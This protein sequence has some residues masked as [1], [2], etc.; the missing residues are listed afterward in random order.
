MVARMN[1]DHRRVGPMPPS[2]NNAMIDGAGSSGKV[3]APPPSRHS[4]TTPSKPK[5]PSSSS[6]SASMTMPSHSLSMAPFP[7]N[8]KRMSMPA[9]SAS[10]SSSAK[11]GGLMRKSSN[12]TSAGKAAESSSSSSSSLHS[13]VHPHSSSHVKKQPGGSNGHQDDKFLSK[14]S[15]SSSTSTSCTSSSSSY[16]PYLSDEDQQRDQ[17]LSF[18]PT[19]YPEYYATHGTRKRAKR[20]H[21]HGIGRD[22]LDPASDSDDPAADDHDDGDCQHSAVFDAGTPPSIPSYFLCPI[23]NTLMTDPVINS[24]GH[25]FERASILRWLVL[26]QPY[27]GT[28]PVTGNALKMED[29][30]EDRV[31]KGAMEKARKEAWVRYILE[32]GG[33]EKDCKE[34]EEKW[35]QQQQQQQPPLRQDKQDDDRHQR[36]PDGHGQ[37][38]ESDSRPE[39][40]TDEKKKEK[41]LK[42]LQKKLEKENSKRHQKQERQ[43]Q[44]EQ[45]SKDKDAIDLEDQDLQQQHPHRPSIASASAKS[46]TSSKGGHHHQ[47]HNHQHHHHSHHNHNHHNHSH[48]PPSSPNKTFKRKHSKQ[49]ELKFTAPDQVPSGMPFPPPPPIASNPKSKPAPPPPAKSHGEKPFRHSNNNINNNNNNNSNRQSI[50]APPP[51]PQPPKPSRRKDNADSG[52][53]AVTSSLSSSLHPPPPPP[54]PPPTTVLPTI[55][56]NTHNP[57]IHNRDRDRDSSSSNSSTAQQILATIGGSNIGLGVGGGG[58]ASVCSAIS[59]PTIHHNGWMAQL[60][61]YKV[62][63]PHP[64][65]VVT[66]DVHRRSRT[67]KRQRRRIIQDGNH[68]DTERSEEE[69]VIPPGS[70]VNV[71][72]TQTHGGRIRG[73]VVWEV[74]EEN[75]IMEDLSSNRKGRLSSGL[76]RTSRF[77]RRGRKGGKNNNE[78]LNSLASNSVMPTKSMVTYT[79]WISL[80][81]AEDDDDDQDILM[82]DLPPPSNAS[83]ASAPSMQ[84]SVSSRRTS[85]FATQTGGSGAADETPGPWTHPIPLGV[86]RVNF[87]AGLPLRETSE[88]DSPVI[89]KLERGRV[90]EVVQTEVKNNRVRARCIVP[91]AVAD[92]D[93]SGDGAA[94]GNKKGFQSGW[95]S[96]LNLSGSSAASPVPL[97]AY[98]TVSESGCIVTDGGRLDSKVKEI[99][100]PGSCIEICSTRIED[101]VVR[102]LLSSG[103]YISLFSSLGKASIAGSRG[104]AVGAA[105]SKIGSG[106]MF[107]MP[108]PLGTY[109]NLQDGLVITSGVSST[110]PM[111]TKLKKDACAEIV[112]TRVE[113]GRVRGRIQSVIYGGATTEANGFINL[114]EPKYRWAKIVSFK[115]GRPVNSQANGSS[116][117]GGDA[118]TAGK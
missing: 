30:M 36:H 56:V 6:V 94:G 80:Q 51:Q 57:N 58:G 112:E 11:T 2:N 64:G 75:D 93:A 8:S 39:Q 111:I 19:Y 31:V 98:V 53:A 74:E 61:V 72:E 9:S 107:A 20:G 118:S 85:A 40:D 48:H 88:R 73:K 32:G 103:G 76:G 96:L 92:E 62:V 46:Q 108:V 97:G 83:V 49:N 63:S 22:D 104:G 7:P 82:S 55:T 91:N 15:Y 12:G 28:S 106:Q 3:I 81:W 78:D 117:N 34:F 54:P 44:Q 115:G 33:E 95:I 18:P 59:T 100:A 41:K 69:L 66:Q 110:S 5:L 109:Q 4:M 23:T 71:I 86:Y 52:P 113:D 60:G 38:S 47:H 42:K 24:E 25:T 101:G 50:T 21:H 37:E 17:L 10:S 105:A 14:N 79:G 77:L 68:E 13:H 26:T 87:G 102:G 35:T 70:F 67:V 43:H 16:S 1:H 90:V 114:F 45:S 29:L 84:S 65:L 116:G 27:G 99:I 89:E